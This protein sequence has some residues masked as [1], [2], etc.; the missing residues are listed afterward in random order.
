MQFLFWVC[1]NNK[2]KKSDTNFYSS[3][4]LLHF[5]AVSN[6]S[7][8]K[9]ELYSNAISLKVLNKKVFTREWSKER[10]IN[11]VT[12]IDWVY[13]VPYIFEHPKKRKMRWIFLGGGMRRS[14]VLFSFFVSCFSLFFSLGLYFSN[15]KSIFWSIKTSWKQG[16]NFTTNGLKNDKWYNPHLSISMAGQQVKRC[17]HDIILINLFKTWDKDELTNSVSLYILHW[18]GILWM[19]IMWE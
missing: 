1:N 7:M 5:K 14:C 19:N 12:G 11:E 15:E 6:I 2:K 18:A 4:Y 8:Q 16:H 10:N 13:I 17:R 3:L 9:S